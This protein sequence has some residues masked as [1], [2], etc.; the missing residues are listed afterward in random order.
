MKLLSCTL[1]VLAT[2]ALSTCSSSSTTRQVLRFGNTVQDYVMFKPNMGY[3]TSQ[4]SLCSWVKQ[5]K[6]GYSHKFWFHYRTPSSGDEIRI[7][8]QG[9]SEMFS[10]HYLYKRNQLNITPGI[11]YHYCMCWSYFSET[12]DVYYNGVK[13]GNMTT[14]SG[15]TLYTGGTL[16]LGRFQ[17]PTDSD[18]A[19]GGELFKLN[20]FSKKFTAAEVKDMYQAGICSEAEKIHGSYRRLTWESILQQTRHGNVQLV[21]VSGTCSLIEVD[22]K[23]AVTQIELEEVEGRLDNK[24]TELQEITSG[25]TETQSR[26]E[27]T[28]SELQEIK[29][30]LTETQ[31]GLE[32][33]QSEL[34]EVKS[35][36]T[37]TQT[38]LETTQSELQEVKSDLERELETVKQQLNRKE[39]EISEMRQRAALT[40]EKL[41]QTQTELNKTKADLKETQRDLSR[42][43]AEFNKTK[44]DLEQRLNQTQTEFNT[45][46]V[47]LE[48]RLNK[49][50]SELK[51]YKAE[52]ELYKIR[53]SETEIS[54]ANISRELQRT[55]NELNLAKTE[56]NLTKTELNLT[57]QDVEELET[58]L[59]ETR[60]NLEASLNETRTDLDEMLDEQN[61]NKKRQ[62]KTTQDLDMLRVQI[63]KTKNRLN[64][65][66][67]GLEEQTLDIPDC[68]VAAAN[69]SRELAVTKLELEKKEEELEK[70]EEELERLRGGMSGEDCRGETSC[71]HWDILYNHCYFNNVLTEEKFMSLNKVWEKLGKI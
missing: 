3:F 50:Q 36:L 57:K 26:L 11:W 46:K 69:V 33:T 62:E 32:T 17:A 67:A 10:H 25:L 29:S 18:W 28:Q 24:E 51:E 40:T 9:F 19:F 21:D 2:L 68:E 41:N 54:S 5:L 65:T 58:N 66:L 44:A 63:E 39:T 30:D 49:T 13:V 23:L 64:Q 56:L 55:K 31:T 6:A 52:S 15:R 27:T 4:F 70:K 20:M 8:V 53:I 1:I 34:Q 45:N 37:E 48:R 7:N 12:T 16:V 14:R 61:Q 38:G 43:Q 42:A 47:D 59:V 60:R 35:D 22:N 71:S